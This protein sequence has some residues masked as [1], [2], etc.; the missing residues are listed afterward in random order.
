[1]RHLLKTVCITSVLFFGACGGANSHESE[2][3]DTAKITADIT[4][5]LAVQDAAWNAG[6]IDGFME[7]YLK[8]D[9]LRFA[10]GGDV[11]KG[12]QT[13]LDNYKTRYPNQDAMGKLS[14]T[15]LEI[16]VLSN[17]YAQ[18]FGRWKLERKIDIPGGLFTLLLQNRDGKWVI[19]SD[20]TSSN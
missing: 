4:A 17:E 3:V 20:H 13:T 15:D 5:M 1:M 10:S 19:I 14:F 8:S 12:W 11:N 7:Y 16:R 18:V 6:D 9:A 2:V